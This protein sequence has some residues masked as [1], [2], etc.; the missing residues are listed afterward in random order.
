MI[1]VCCTQSR[2][3][4][5][6]GVPLVGAAMAAMDVKVDAVACA[7]H[8]R[9]EKRRAAREQ[10]GVLPL[11]GIGRPRAR[12]SSGKGPD[13]KMIIVAR[14]DEDVSYLSLYFPEIPHTVYQVS[15]H[16]PV[17]LSLD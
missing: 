7:A 15:L 2:D 12:G 10:G 17:L 14:A 5:P 11:K 1:R 9:N 8:E 4:L 16:N 13:D 3:Q 6:P